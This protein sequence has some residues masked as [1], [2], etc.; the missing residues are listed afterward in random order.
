MLLILITGLLRSTQV[1]H[2]RLEYAHRRKI[3]WTIEQPSSS[4]LIHFPELE[5]VR[6]ATHSMQAQQTLSVRGT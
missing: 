3:Y 4:V 2:P 5:A 1:T 6:V